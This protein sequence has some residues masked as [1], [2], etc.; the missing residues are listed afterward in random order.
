MNHRSWILLAIVCGLSLSLITRVF[1]NQ[2]THARNVRTTLSNLRRIH[3]AVAQYVS[4][5]GSDD[6][7]EAKLPPLT[8]LLPTYVKPVW[9]KSPCANFRGPSTT[10]WEHLGMRDSHS[11][12]AS[13]L[14]CSEDSYWQN[15]LGAK[16]GLGVNRAGKLIDFIAYG[17]A[18]MARWWTDPA[19]RL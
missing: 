2:A 14:S 19:S 17:D 9:M 7:D 12:L 8:A 18:S 10:Y 6:F 13:D 1:S 16:R 3:E 4:D 5:I 11:I 15:R